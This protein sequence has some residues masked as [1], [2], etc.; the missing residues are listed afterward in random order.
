MVS[1]EYTFEN[2]NRMFLMKR[3]SMLDSSDCILLRQLYVV[4][5]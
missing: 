1:F 5:Y 4:V 3:A 2:F